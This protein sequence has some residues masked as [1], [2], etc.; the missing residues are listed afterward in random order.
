MGHLQF[1][2]VKFP[3]RATSAKLDAICLSC[4]I[5]RVRQRQEALPADFLRLEWEPSLTVESVETARRVE[6]GCASRE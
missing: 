6:M 4:F 5:S 2:R 3:R 1:A